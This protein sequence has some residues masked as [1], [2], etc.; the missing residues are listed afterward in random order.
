MEK[1]NELKIFYNNYPYISL[2]KNKIRLVKRFKTSEKELI[3][4]H[5]SS[6]ISLDSIILENLN[7]NIT[8]TNYRFLFLLSKITLSEDSQKK[9]ANFIDNFL[10]SH[11]NS[12]NKIPHISYIFKIIPKLTLFNYEE[13]ILSLRKNIIF[14]LYLLEIIELL[15]AIGRK[16][17]ISMLLNLIKEFPFTRE[18][19]FLSIGKIASYKNFP[20]VKRAYFNDYLVFTLKLLKNKKNLYNDSLF[21]SLCEIFLVDN[22]V[23]GKLQN[24]LIEILYFRKDSSSLLPIT[25][26]ILNNLEIS[27]KDKQLLSKFQNLKFDFSFQ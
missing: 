21:Y 1:F 17:S 4:L 19:C 15:G 11:C 27:S 2:V 7:Q 10:T 18:L 9:L 16:N 24:K 22:G 12:L 13:F 20:T 14:E 23:N 26:K 25:I 5:N 3:L 8:F 6:L